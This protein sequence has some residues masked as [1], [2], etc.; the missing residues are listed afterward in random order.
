M[1]FSASYLLGL[2][3]L[4]IANIIWA[5]AS[6]LQQYI[7]DDLGFSS[8]FVLTY[9]GTSVFLLFLPMHELSL[10]LGLGRIK[11][12]PA[13]YGFEEGLRKWWNLMRNLPSDLDE[14]ANGR[15][16]KEGETEHSSVPTRASEGGTDHAGGV[17]SSTL[18][19]APYTHFQAFQVACFIAPAW[20]T[21]NLLYNYSLY[22]TTITSSTVISN[23]SAAF[24]LFL[25]WYTSLEVFTMGKVIGVALSFTG[26]VMVTLHDAN[27]EVDTSHRRSLLGEQ[28]ANTEYSIIGDTMAL[29]SAILYGC[30]IVIVR[31][32]TKDEEEEEEEEEMEEKEEEKEERG[33]GGGEDVV[34]RDVENP[35]SIS[36]S[37]SADTTHVAMVGTERAGIRSTREGSTEHNAEI[38]SHVDTAN[39]APGQPE[40]KAVASASV[41]LLARLG[42]RKVQVPFSL[43]LGY[44]G[45][46]VM[47]TLAPVL[48][49]L[50]V[51]CKEGMC[52]LSADAVA[53]ILLLALGA[54]FVSEYFW[55]R[56]MLLT[57]PTVA[58]V[59]LS[60]TI[61]LAYLSDIFIGAP[62]AGSVLS[63]IGALLVVSGFVMCNVEDE[64]WRGLCRLSL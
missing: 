49:G 3:F 1:A 60:M 19:P 4:L 37:S 57:T 63:G 17:D 39:S 23:L 38:S 58:T 21:G 33:E 15:L 11:C 25:S 43:V 29:V 16:L 59:G 32:T 8:P 46:I 36:G 61:P 56:S 44:V 2:V 54:N 14:S 41:G 53:Y 50:G 5:C 13:R 48:L 31:M 24:T 40:D 22:W 51:T 52:A 10:R 42:L 30:Y 28:G 7:Y 55:A 27:V 26:A 47:V 35:I 9:V 12:Q 34:G 18:P 62:G 45:M 20:F 6:V 64:T